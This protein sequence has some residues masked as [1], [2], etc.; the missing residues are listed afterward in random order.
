MRC[1][2]W[3]IAFVFAATS[4]HAAAVSPPGVNLRWDDC[5]GDGGAS[6]KNFACDTNSGS[7]R[8]VCSFELSQPMAQIAAVKVTWDVRAEGPTLPP[9]WSFYSLGTCR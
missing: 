9:W 1:S 6:N 7:E 8:L 3:L 5:Y 4:A 2:H